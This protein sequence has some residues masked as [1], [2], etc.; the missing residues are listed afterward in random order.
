MNRG[1]IERAYRQAAAGGPV[2]LPPKTTAFRT[3]AIGLEQ[4]VR[5]PRVADA[6]GRLPGSHVD[7][8]GYAGEVEI[9]RTP[10][11]D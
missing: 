4:L 10:G 7:L 11:R 3:W 5:S 2:A 1:R 8:L 9:M 6:A